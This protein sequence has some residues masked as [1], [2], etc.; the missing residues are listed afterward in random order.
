MAV[1]R[2]LQYA[3]I[4]VYRGLLLLCCYG[5]SVYRG[6]LYAVVA[7]LSSPLRL[8]AGLHTKSPQRPSASAQTVD[9]CL[10]T[11]TV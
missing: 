5:C 10:Q 2:G 6:L 4:A 1:Y 8:S 3:A 9:G 11:L 7:V